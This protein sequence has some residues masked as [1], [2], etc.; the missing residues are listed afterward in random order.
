M[1][2]IAIFLTGLTTGG[3]S[4]LAMQGG[5]LTSVISNQKGEELGD[6]PVAT[7]L[8]KI[9][10]LD[11]QPALLFLAAKLVSHTML[12][13][14]LGWLGSQF[15]LNLTVRLL[16][17]AVAAFFMLAT[18]GN[19]LNLHPLFR[20]VVIQPPR[21]VQRLVKNSTKSKAIFTPAVLGFL[22]IF[23]P[24]GITQAM[25]VLAV[26]SGSAV[27]G[28][29]ILFFF[30]L[31]TSPLFALLGIATAK[32]S[33]RFTQTFMKVA[34]ATL[35]FLALSSL[36]GILVVLDAPLTINK[37]TQPISYFFSEE[38]FAQKGLVGTETLDDGTQVVVIQ[39]KSNGYSPN[40]IMVKAGIPVQLTLQTQDTYSCAS[41]FILKAFNIRLQLGPTDSETV[42]FTPTEVGKFPFTCSMGMYSGV[43][44]VI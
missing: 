28:A 19:L 5:L 1:N 16:F 31:G 23:I 35:V 12:G 18:A 2:L 17:Q 37:I 13:F 11:W 40:K 14:L 24:C 25:E 26:T 39:V 15:E 38:R 42:Y 33:E 6:K 41:S 21:F 8:K 3:L 29:L 32:L 43:L 27:M 34:A 4:C 10:L 20:Y 9:D 44:E 36:N 30:V 7:S 22:T